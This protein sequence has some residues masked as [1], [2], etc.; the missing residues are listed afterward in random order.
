MSSLT[1]GRTIGYDLFPVSKLNGSMEQRDVNA[2][3]E[4]LMALLSFNAF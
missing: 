1:L 3:V 4:I 2:R